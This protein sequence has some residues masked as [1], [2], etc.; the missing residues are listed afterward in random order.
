MRLMRFFSIMERG[1]REH[2]P[3]GKKQ[4]MPSSLRFLPATHHTTLSTYLDRPLGQVVPHRQ[5]FIRMSASSPCS[6]TPCS[7]IFRSSSV[8][9]A[10]CGVVLLAPP[11][12]GLGGMGSSSSS[13][14]SIN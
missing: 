7:S 2:L 6:Y 14:S 4:I 1:K 9:A 8:R 12:L 10:A 3:W 5:H 13:S 11:H